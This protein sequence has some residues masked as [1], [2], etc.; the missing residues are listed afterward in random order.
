MTVHQLPLGTGG[1]EG[2]EDAVLMFPLFP[3]SIENLEAL[4]SILRCFVAQGQ[5]GFGGYVLG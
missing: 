2:V 4:E 3:G 1:N 5:E